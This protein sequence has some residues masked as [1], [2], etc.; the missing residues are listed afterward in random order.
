MK[1]FAAV[2]AAIAL[3]TSA[4]AAFSSCGASSDDFQL[5]SVTYTPNP[6]KV[7]QSVCITLNGSLNKAV[8]QGAT[9]R[10]TATFWG[11]T[12]Y[13]QTSDLCAA[14]VNGTNPCPISQ[15]VKSVT[16][17]ISVPS[18][19]PAGVQLQI[20]AVATNAGNTRIFCI[21]GPLTFSN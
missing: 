13:D 7:G 6:P 10:T 2:A 19:V 16:Q 18:N 1:F 12:A 15:D 17:C 14:L 5:S 8:T 3:A 11:I 21:N 20:K 4:S 9:I